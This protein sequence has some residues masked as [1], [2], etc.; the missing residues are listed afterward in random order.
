MNFDKRI[1]WFM[2]NG[3]KHL[4]DWMIRVNDKRDGRLLYQGRKY[5]TALSFVGEKKFTAIDIG[6]HVGLWSW[7]MAKDFTRVLAFEPMPEHQDCFAKNMQAEI[8]TGQVA[9]SPVALGPEC[10]EAHIRTRTVGSSGDTGI[11]WD[12]SGIKVPML[13]LDSF[14]IKEAN[15]MK[16][17][18][19]GYELFVLQGAVETLKRCRPVIIVEQK[20]ET[21]GPVR[22]RIS[23]TA[24][25]E[26]L[27]TLGM[28]QRAAI[29]GDYIMTW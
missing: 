16:I 7:Q 8:A 4:P 11:E 22:Y 21:G 25:V 12:G 10:G 28:R 15:F 18:C 9:L 24:A 1:G 19:E 23:T 26:F 29:Q 6:A 17:D 3:E 27:K 13:T 20:P 5:R 14:G 2:P